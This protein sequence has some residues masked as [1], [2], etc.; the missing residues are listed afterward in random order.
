MMWAESCMLL[1]Q[2]VCTVEAASRGLWWKALYW[3][4]ALLLTIAI[5]KGMKT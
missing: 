4:G 5:V 1:L 3:F 2:I